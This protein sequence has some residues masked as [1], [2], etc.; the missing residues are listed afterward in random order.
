MSVVRRAEAKE[1]ADGRAALEECKLQEQ[2]AWDQ[3]ENSTVQ[4]KV[5]QKELGETKAALA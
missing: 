3:N 5:A 2:I 1:L 4:L